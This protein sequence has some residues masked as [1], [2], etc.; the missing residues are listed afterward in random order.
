L[1]GFLPVTLKED[2][3]NFIGSIPMF[4]DKKSI[5]HY[6]DTSA[7]SFFIDSSFRTSLLNNADKPIPS[8]SVNGFRLN[9]SD[10]N[11]G[12]VDQSYLNQ[13]TSKSFETNL[14]GL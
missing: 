7:L 9:Q 3:S 4:S 13:L 6:L 5:S 1:R 12:I 2:D 14:K 10:S 11:F 8:I